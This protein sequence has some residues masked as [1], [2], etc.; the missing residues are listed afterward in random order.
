VPE[1]YKATPDT[2]LIVDSLGIMHRP[3]VNT[4]TSNVSFKNH[5]TAKKLTALF[6]KIWHNSEPTPYTR[7]MII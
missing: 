6:D 2:F 1:Q 7:E 5:P 4:I 3:S